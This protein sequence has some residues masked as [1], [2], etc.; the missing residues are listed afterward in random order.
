MMDHMILTEGRQSAG[1]RDIGLYVHIPFCARK[2]GYC[3]FLSFS[4]DESTKRRYVSALKNEIRMAGRK[5]AGQKVVSVYIGGGTPTYLSAGELS[6]ILETVFCAFSVAEDA[7]IT[8]EANPGTLAADKLACMRR[9]GINRLSIGLQAVDNRQLRLLGRIH[10]YETFLENYEAA[11]RVGFD[12]INVDL[13][14]GIPGQDAGQWEDTLRQVARLSPEHISA[15]TLILEEETPFYDMY[16]SGKTAHRI[17]APLPDEDEQAGMYELTSP[18]L[19]AWGYERYEVSNYARPGMACRHNMG[20]WRRTP[21][22]GVG[23]G[24]ASLMDAHRF[25]QTSDMETY[26]KKYGQTDCFDDGSAASIWEQYEDVESLGRTE[27]MK[28]T[29]LL[30][31][32]MTSGVGRKS[33]RDTFLI[34]PA[35]A[36]SDVISR[37]SSLGLLEVTGEA[38]RLTQRGMEVGNHVFM[39][40]I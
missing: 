19:S 38:I 8:S 16:V 3:D 2:C 18:I 9:A 14:S 24:A 12:N 30:G 37:M 25:R 32:R 29:M 23:L 34:D 36:F 7:E 35:E 27:Q 15:Y 1:K 33:F 26:L 10:T 31:L 39:E 6:G 13:I 20:Y 22:I 4:A 5:M 11:R 28:E 17:L 40:F 21:Y